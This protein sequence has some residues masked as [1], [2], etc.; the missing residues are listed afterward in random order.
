M[1]RKNNNI[2]AKD[3]TEDFENL[4]HPKS[5]LVFYESDDKCKFQ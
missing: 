5:A 1:K 3:V 2:E 4:Y